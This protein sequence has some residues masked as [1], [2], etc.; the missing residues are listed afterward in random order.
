MR[1]PAITTDADALIEREARKRSECLTN[2][3]IA[4]QTGQSRKYIA[5]RVA[6][7]RRKIESITI[8]VKPKINVNP[9]VSDDD[10]N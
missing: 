7:M 8:H 4:E 3:Q 5:A 1:R 10:S 9:D 2:K 6:Y